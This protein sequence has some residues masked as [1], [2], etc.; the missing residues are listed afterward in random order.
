[1]LYWLIF[2]RL[3][4]GV[5]LCFIA[6]VFLLGVFASG[7]YDRLH[8]KHDAPETVIDEVAGQSIALLPLFFWNFN[9]FYPAL[10]SLLAF[11]L[12]R[13]FDI[14]KPLGVWHIQKLPGGW[15]VMLDDVLAGFYAL[16]V[17]LLIL[18]SVIFLWF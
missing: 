2:R 14:V 6:G 4:A 15:G 8:G 12:F 5:Y 18:L 9:G 13:F 1:L 11:I 7:E 3:D 10:T 17:W 16:G